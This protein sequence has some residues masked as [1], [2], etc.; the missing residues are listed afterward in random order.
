MI[1]KQL[2]IIINLLL[3]KNRKVIKIKYRGLTIR[4]SS[5]YNEKHEKALRMREYLEDLEAKRKFVFLYRHRILQM[6]SK[7]L[8]KHITRYFDLKKG[9]CLIVALIKLQKI[10]HFAN[11]HYI[12]F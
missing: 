6:Y 11:H 8:Q 7:I 10:G 9:I 12:V 1:Q 2:R 4:R 3:T 5:E